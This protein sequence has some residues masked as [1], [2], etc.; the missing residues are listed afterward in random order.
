[1]DENKFAFD[2]N[3]S[4]FLQKK[5]CGKCSVSIRSRAMANVPCDTPK[6]DELALVKIVDSNT[7]ELSIL[8]KTSCE[9]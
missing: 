3:M 4:L 9:S 8:F 6:T 5:L 1:M 2:N 7:V